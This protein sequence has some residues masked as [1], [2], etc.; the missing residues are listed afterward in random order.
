M[1]DT[2]NISKWI[3]IVEG[4]L[5]NDV[6]KVDEEILEQSA[7]GGC[8]DWECPECFPDTEHES[9][10]QQMPGIIIVQP[11]NQDNNMGNEYPTATSTD[12]DGVGMAGAK[13]VH[14]PTCGHSNDG[15]DS[16]D[17]EVDVAMLPQDDEVEFEEDSVNIEQKKLPRSGGGVKLGHIVQKFVP[18]VVAPSSMGDGEVDEATG[19]PKQTKTKQQDINLDPYADSDIFG[20][21]DSY[22]LAEPDDGELNDTLPD[23]DNTIPHMPTAS[24]SSTRDK[25]ANMTPS[26]TMRDF[27]NR[28]NPE[29]GGDE[30][31]LEINPQDQENA[32]VAR[33]A[34]DVPAVISSAMRIAG[35]ESPEWHHVGNLPGFASRNIRG[36][37]RNIFSMFTSTPLEKIQTVANVDGQGPNTESEVRAVASWL[38]NNAEDLGTVELSHGQAIPGYHPDV[39]EYSINGVRFHVVRDPMGHYIYAYPDADARTNQGNGRIENNNVLR[40]DTDM[41]R[42]R[43]SIITLSLLESLEWDGMV[44]EAMAEFEVEES[45]LSKSLGKSS[46]RSK[47][48]NTLISLMHK[49]HKLDND[50][51]LNTYPYSTRM[52]WKQFKSN[53][54][55]FMILKG[56]NGVAAIKPSLESFN[57]RKK[58]KEAKGGVYNPEE[59]TYLQYQVVAYMDDGDKVDANFLRMPPAKDDEKHD[60]FA[61][62]DIMRT[63]GGDPRKRDTEYSIFDKLRDTIGELRFIWVARGYKGKEDMPPEPDADAKIDAST[64]L[65]HPAVNREKMARRKELKGPENKELS[66]Y[67]AMDAVF[68]KIRPVMKKVANQ[69]IMLVK[70]RLIRALEQDSPE[71]VVDKYKNA[72]T[73]INRFLMAIDTTKDV[74]TS[75]NEMALFKNALIS[76]S[77]GHQTYSKEFT[78]YLNSL[79]K[80]NTAALQPVFAAIRDSLLGKV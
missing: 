49:N 33:T 19:A 11:D 3:A 78:N 53:P 22:P 9:A 68:K 57:K 37:G 41:P 77:G 69:A 38:H 1:V 18:D 31:E 80:G 23:Q 72:L 17:H 40:K 29:A 52:F 4:T 79:L 25:T 44:K 54:D 71:E 64:V 20:S 27:M 56:A 5:P 60:T 15:Q 61:D 48:A 36:I 74:S 50:A 7:C 39:K 8:D 59:D 34:S 16:H 24:A 43:E 28:I 51:I 26:D 32:L 67:E 55:Q 6:V 65:H 35:E 45:T 10:L 13:P 66:S 58:A 76:A 21:Q 12:Q 42:L 63:R 30:P 73:K 62:K 70:P 2:N 14:C 75:S 46:K 47:G